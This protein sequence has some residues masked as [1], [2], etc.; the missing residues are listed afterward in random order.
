MNVPGQVKVVVEKSHPKKPT[1]GFQPRVRGKNEAGPRL[2][3]VTGVVK[4]VVAFLWVSQ[5]T[6]SVVLDSLFGAV[7]GLRCTAS[8][9]FQLR[10]EPDQRFG[11][12][13]LSKAGA[14][15]L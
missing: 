1:A 14:V 4:V 3:N 8:M 9:G 13:P 10:V 11:L 12:Y 6:F 7:V 15:I 5:A 2:I